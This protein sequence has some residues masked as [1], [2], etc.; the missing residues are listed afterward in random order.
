LAEPARCSVGSAALHWITAGYGYEVTGADV[1]AACSIA[2]AAARM[3][4]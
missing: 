1:Q 4:R 2:L 3:G